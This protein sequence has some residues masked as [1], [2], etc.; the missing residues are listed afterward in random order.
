MIPELGSGMVQTLASGDVSVSPDF[1]SIAPQ[2]PA[3]DNNER[4]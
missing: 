3:Q 4:S 1:C 2:T